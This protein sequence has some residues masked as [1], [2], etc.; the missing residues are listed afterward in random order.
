M[1]VATGPPHLHVQNG[2]L[3]WFNGSMTQDFTEQERAALAQ[4][5]I[6]DIRIRSDH[7]LDG[8]QHRHQVQAQAGWG[9]RQQQKRQRCTDL[10]GGGLPAGR[11]ASSQ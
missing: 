8:P 4:A 11:T 2:S 9:I 6:L 10:E 3:V 5:G 7:R 1:A